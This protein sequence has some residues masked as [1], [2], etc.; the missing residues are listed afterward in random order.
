MAN[1]TCL[2]CLIA[3]GHLPAHMVYESPDVLAFLDIRPIR[4]GHVQIIPREHFDYYDTVPLETLTEIV[5]VGQ[6]LAPILSNLFEVKR[7]AFLFTGGD[8]PHVH[9]HVVPIVE[10]TDINSK[11][12]IVEQDITFQ[13]RPRVPDSE[14]SATAKSLRL[15]LQ[16]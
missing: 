15:M 3:A 4:T 13:D 9:A 5:S 11:Q 16:E 1:K 8:I 12:Y 14:L 10:A 2:F 7:V 6:Q